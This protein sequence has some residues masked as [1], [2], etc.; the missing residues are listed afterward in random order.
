MIY[1]PLFIIHYLPSTI[2][3]PLPTIYYLSSII[4]AIY[5]PLPIKYY[6]TS[7][8][9]PSPNVSKAFTLE[10]RQSS[11]KYRSNYLYQIQRKAR[12]KNKVPVPQLRRILSLRVWYSTLSSALSLWAVDETCSPLGAVVTHSSLLLLSLGII[13]TSSAGMTISIS[14]KNK[15]I[16]SKPK[17]ECRKDMHFENQP[18]SVAKNATSRPPAR[19]C[20]NLRPGS[21]SLDRSPI[22]LPTQLHRSCCRELCI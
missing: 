3:H 18:G 22:A 10:Q 5:N 20:M 9:L 1:H 21:G 11:K 8:W 17:F 7:H 12:V 13:F 16:L 2:Y 4:P 6:P 19:N 15:G 14:S